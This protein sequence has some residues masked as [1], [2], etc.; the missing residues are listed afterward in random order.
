M[1][2][3]A[4]INIHEVVEQLPPGS[5]LTLHDVSWEEYE[6]LLEAVGEATWLR[7]SYDE[8]TMEIMTVSSRHESLSTLIERMMDRLSIHLRIKI[9]FFGSATMR[10]R[11]KKKGNEP[12]ACFYLRSADLIGNKIDIDFESD[13]PPDI[14][15]E[16]DV[17]HGSKPKFGIYA[18][19]GVPE[20]W[21][22]DQYALRI[23]QLE[24]E[25]YV[26]AEASPALPILTSNKLT[27]FLN[28]SFNEDQ[29]EVLLAFEKWLGTLKKRGK[30]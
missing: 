16:V 7:I 1:G 25:E 23:Y 17:H 27:E 30:K 18:A 4:P 21:L 6:D 19:L 9:L 12:D 8:G 26:E 29:H 28:R 10:K 13:P 24:D 11:R 22:Y 3:Q 5:T 15:V 2:T 14:A 20:I